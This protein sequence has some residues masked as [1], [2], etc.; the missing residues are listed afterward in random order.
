LPAARVGTLALYVLL[1]G[2]SGVLAWLGLRAG[3]SSTLVTGGIIVAAFVAIVVLERLLPYRREWLRSHGDVWT[4]TLHMAVTTGLA[5][6]GR[7]FNVAAFALL[8]ASGTSAG[9][10]P[11]AW[12]LAAQL[13]LAMLIE[14]LAGYWIHR[15]QHNVPL[16][17]RF[18]SVHHTA[19]RLYW[20]NQAR[21]HPIDALVSSA[22]ILP[23]AALGAPDATLSVFTVVLSVHLALQ[24]SNIDLRL[25]RLNL[26]LASG[27]VHRWHH[28]RR[29]EESN[30]NYGGFLYI[31]DVLFGTGV[32]PSEHPPVDTGLSDDRGYPQHYLGQLRAP[33]RRDLFATSPA[34]STAT[35][36]SA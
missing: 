5:A 33:F 6:G 18:H 10:W 16:F 20:L 14:E 34:A 29:L 21:N 17:W 26:L 1:V 13:A 31:F 11:S 25:G 15:V 8:G 12:P 3:Y 7:W 35:S 32:L 28:S 36:G 27:E 4:D 9:L 24:H 19:P 2:G 30:A 22:A 23:V